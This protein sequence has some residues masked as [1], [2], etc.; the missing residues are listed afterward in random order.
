VD[1]AAS[2]LVGLNSA[3]ASIGASKRSSA[4][5]SANSSRT[6]KIRTIDRA[7]TGR[8]TRSFDVV[9]ASAPDAAAAST[10]AMI[11]SGR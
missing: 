11:S 1:V 6:D 9:T 3:R 2:T 4:A 7:A 8:R 5:S 10:N